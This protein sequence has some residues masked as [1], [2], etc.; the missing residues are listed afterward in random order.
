MK[1]FRL[2]FF[3]FSFFSFSLFAS[4]QVPLLESYPS[5]S[6]VVFLDFD[7]HVV[8]GTSWNGSGPIVCDPAGF[9]AAQITTIFNR[10]AED[11]RPFTLNITTDSTKYWA[12]PATHRMR[13]VLT[14]SSS[15]YGS[16]G[17]VSY[18]NS[19]TWGDNSPC[20]VF[21]ALLNNNLKYIAEAASHEI[22]HTLGLRHQSAYD[23]QCNKLSEYNIGRG[24]GEIGWA[25]IMGNSYYENMT[26]WHYGSNPFGCNDIQDDLSIILGNDNGISYRTDDFGNTTAMAATATFTANAFSMQGIIEQ[27]GDVDAVK[28]TVSTPGRFT[29]DASPYSIATGNVGADL[30]LEVSLADNMG[31]V[32]G[33]YNDPATLNTQIDTT[34]STGAYYLLVQGKGNIYAPGYASLG[35]YTL[36]ATLSGNSPLPVHKLQLKAATEKG[37]HKLDWEIVADEKV[38]S[39]TIEVATDAKG[40]QSLASIEASQRTYTYRPSATGL[41][42]YRVKVL[43]DNGRVYY[44]NTV[45]LRGSDALGKPSLVGNV[46]SGTLTVSSPSAYTYAVFD[47]AGRAVAKGSVTQGLNVISPALSSNGIYLIQFENG[48]ERW[49]EKFSKQ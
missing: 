47:V 7:G 29:L 36:N 5:S 6:N 19:F 3:L 41:F 24:S 37:Q 21:T 38:I 34:L 25:P 35:S 9:D 33:V 16:A 22:G 2:P 20:F 30:D 43:F 45:A 39:Q 42:Y 27:P 28:F 49:A 32:L 26:L 18:I 12:A 15:W 1:A 46:T 14:T 4:A 44:S 40:L 48:A 23:A 8:E 17:G 31:N 10:V 13:V 11:Y